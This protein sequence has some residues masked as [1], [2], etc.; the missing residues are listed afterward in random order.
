[1]MA[2]AAWLLAEA[3]GRS[4]AEDLLGALDA[5]PKAALEIGVLGSSLDMSD[6]ASIRVA[7]LG[8]LSQCQPR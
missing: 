5:L 6:Y 8:P 2:L 3:A 7:R 1:M 4:G